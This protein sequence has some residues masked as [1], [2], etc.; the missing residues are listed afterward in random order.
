MFSS[1]GSL[2]DWATEV[3]NGVRRIDR[4]SCLKNCSI[5]GDIVLVSSSGFCFV[6]HVDFLSGE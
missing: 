3:Y 5:S 6:F 2:V 1:E 4:E